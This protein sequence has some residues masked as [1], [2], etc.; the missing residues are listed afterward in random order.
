[1]QW[2]IEHH[3]AGKFLIGKEVIL[4]DPDGLG[5]RPQNDPIL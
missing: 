1:L 4:G 5:L 3:L 2:I